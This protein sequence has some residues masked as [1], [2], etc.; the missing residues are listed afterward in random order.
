MA[1]S[2]MGIAASAVLLA[3]TA[4]GAHAQAAASWPSAGTRLVR[5]EEPSTPATPDAPSEACARRLRDPR[6]GREYLLRHSSAKRD[7]AR[8]EAGTTTT[9]TTR[10]L[11]A[12]GDYGRIELK[13]DTLST[14]LV[15]V[16]CT[17]SRVVA[18]RAGT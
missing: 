7:V 14:R 18:R 17:T 10:L 12:V 9:T 11:D 13:G 8:Q 2:L 1:R 6:T 15:T 5:I 16:D 4:R 3:C